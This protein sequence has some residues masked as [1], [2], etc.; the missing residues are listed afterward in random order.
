M[1]KI[2]VLGL[3]HLGC[4]YGACLAEKRFKVV[5]F[6]L[7]EKVVR[8]LQ[9]N[10]PPIFEPG[11]E[12]LIRKH[13][14]KN[15]VFTHTASEAIADKDYVFITLDTPVDNK[16]QIQLESFNLLIKQVKKFINK[17][18]TLV[19]SSQVPVGTCRSIGVNRVLYFP[20]NLR[21]GQAIEIFLNPER[22]VLGGEEKLRKKF[23]ADFAFWKSPIVEMSLES[24]EMSKHT[25]NSYLSVMISFSSEVSDLCERLGA[26]ALDVMNALKTDSRVSVK[27]PL[28]PGIGFA[29]GTL[30]RDL[31][32]LKM[33]AKKVNYNP[34]LIKAAYQV[35][36]D[37]LPIFVEKI[38]KVLGGLNNK[39]VGL[40]GLTY[41]PGTNTLRRSQSLELERILEKFGAKVCAT[42]PAI[43]GPKY[44]EFFQ[45]LDAVVLMTPWEEFRSLLPKDLAKAMKRKIIFDARNFLDER[46]YKKAGFRYFSVGR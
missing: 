22:I 21:L 9:N 33:M 39:K 12:D 46:A 11:L 3:W 1:R 27:A 7:E 20:E 13:N 14:N 2:G 36:Q 15:L 29:G 37:R 19:V 23:L 43:N 34:K 10:T 8:N 26:N 45:G 35:N 24:A 18:T 42:D 44:D 40:L 38:R 32:T 30:G 41:K 17:K 5:G 25:L 28:N 4:V 16:D 31:Q 6:D